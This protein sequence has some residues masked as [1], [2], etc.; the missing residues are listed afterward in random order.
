ME[1]IDCLGPELWSETHRGHGTQVFVKTQC[2]YVVTV[3]CNVVLRKIDSCSC[4]KAARK[5]A[6]TVG[7]DNGGE[8]GGLHCVYGQKD[9][10]IQTESL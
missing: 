10:H 6:K 3:N 1:A 7:K 5:S 2:F 9:N 4:R 8:S